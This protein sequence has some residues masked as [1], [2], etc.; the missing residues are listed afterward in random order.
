MEHFDRFAGNLAGNL[1]IAD[2][3]VFSREQPK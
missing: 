2:C 1:P 3:P